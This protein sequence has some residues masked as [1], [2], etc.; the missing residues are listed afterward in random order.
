[1]ARSSLSFA[2]DGKPLSPPVRVVAQSS[3]RDQDGFEHPSDPSPAPLQVF[4]RLSA[5]LGFR[6]LGRFVRVSPGRNLRAARSQRGGQDHDPAHLEHGAAANQ[7]PRHR[8]RP[9]RATRATGGADQYRLHV[10]Q[11]RHLRPDDRLGTGRVFRPALWLDA[12]PP[13]RTNG[14]DFRLAQD[15]RLSRRAGLEDVHGHETE[16][17]DRPDHRARSACLDLRRAD[18]RSRRPGAARGLAEDRRAARSK[19]DHHFFDAFDARGRKALPA[20]GDHPQRAAPVRGN[21]PRI[22]RA[23]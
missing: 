7:R 1:M 21:A 4:P 16:G 19:Q 23:V 9:R 22:A 15:E 6:G 13:A 2:A 5:G 11:H 17:L 18:F 3:T 8:G 14:N 20:C 10:G 12:R